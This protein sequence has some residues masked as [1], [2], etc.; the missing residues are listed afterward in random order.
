MNPG[1]F[2]NVPNKLFVYKSYVEYVLTGFGIK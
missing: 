2:K 1:S